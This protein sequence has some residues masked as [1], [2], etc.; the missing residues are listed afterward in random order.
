MPHENIGKLIV[1]ADSSQLGVLRSYQQKA[2][3]N[4][5]GQLRWVEKDELHHLEPEVLGVA[6]VYSPTTGIIDSHSYMLALQ[7]DFEGAGGMVAFNSKVNRLIYADSLVVE[8]DDI[9]LAPKILVNAAGLDAP[10]LSQSIGNAFETHYAIGHY[11][12]LSGKSPFNRLVYPIAESGGLGVHVTLDI[13]HQVRFG[14]DVRWIDSHDYTFD[15]SQRDRF[16]AAIRAYYPGL[17]G[18]EAKSWVHR[19]TP[20]TCT[21]RKFR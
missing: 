19:D 5:A 4:G 13:A 12:T 10:R 18:V 8:C 2:N 20:K 14:P 16:V 17:D 1:A 7:G 9:A 11:Y 15:D 3:T 21:S 6:A